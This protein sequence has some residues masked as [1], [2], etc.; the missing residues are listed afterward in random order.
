MPPRFRL[1]T[2]K[3][4]NQDDFQVD[5]VLVIF[6]DLTFNQTM[7]FNELIFKRTGP[8]WE[9][10]IRVLEPLAIFDGFD[11]AY[12]CETLG[13]NIAKGF[14]NSRTKAKK[15]DRAATKKLL[16]AA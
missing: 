7:L 2:A 16:D 12:R 4:L 1:V 10:M 13:K 8:D 15:R 6:E 5:R 11:V 3:E 14:D 9:A